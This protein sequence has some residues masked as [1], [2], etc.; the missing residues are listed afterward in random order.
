MKCGRFIVDTHGHI[1]TLYDSVGP[2]PNPPGWT[3]LPSKPGAG[4]VEHVD[5]TGLTLWDMDCYGVDMMLL[6]PSVTGTLNE[7]QLEI[8]KA[9]PD[10]FRAFCSDQ[11]TRLRCQ[12][13][14]I[15]WKTD[16][17]ARE[18]DDALSTGMYCGIGE[19]MPQDWDKYY[20]FQDR[21]AEYRVFMDIARAHKVPVAFHDVMWKYEWDA[22]KLLFR[23]ATEY[24]DVPI[25][26]NHGG[27]SIGCY[28]NN[29][30]AIRKSLNI[31]GNYMAG[32]NIYLETGTWST[33][34]ILLAV[35]DPNVG[36]TRLLWGG[37]YGNV[38]QYQTVSRSRDGLFPRSINTA[39]RNWKAVPP[40]QG[41]WWGWSL[42]QF[43]KLKDYVSQDVINLILGGNAAKLFK[44]PVPYE[45]MFMCGR[46]DYFGI[47][48][49]ESIP[50]IPIEQVRY[51]DDKA[52]NKAILEERKKNPPKFNPFE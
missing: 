1:S 17:A 29:D 6:Y 30:E 9:H 28:I 18:I 13:E 41:D 32:G 45:R 5:N 48:W 38:P 40:Y 11:S 36:P 3:G 16:D 35:E 7:H 44:L 39:M 52:A 26:V 37:D 20:T 31:A 21:L 24:P 10:K 25:I 49:E 34:M 22:W 12:R 51:P 8:C 46:P 23:V 19:F 2:D 33:E 43:E 14:G 15:A 50:Y 27:Y 4:E 42:H 47:N